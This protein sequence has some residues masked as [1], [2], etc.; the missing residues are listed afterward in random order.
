MQSHKVA[1]LSI[2]S[3]NSRCVIW[4]SDTLRTFMDDSICVL[5]VSKI[6]YQS[7]GIC[8]AINAI[9]HAHCMHIFAY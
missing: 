1:S 5:I 4:G 3:H 9:R 7:G 6:F 2:Q 8:S